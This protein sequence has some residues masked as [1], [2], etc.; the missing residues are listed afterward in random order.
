M[1]SLPGFG[2][3]LPK[4]AKPKFELI[5]LCYEVAHQYCFQYIE[6][7]H[8]EL[9][10]TL[11]KGSGEEIQ[12]E[13]YFF[14]DKGGRKLG[15]RFDLTVPL[16]RFISDHRNEIEIPFKRFTYGNV[17][18]GEKPQKGRYRE[19][20]QIDFDIVGDSSQYSEIEILEVISGVLKRLG[21]KFQIHVNDRRIL[22]FLAAS[23]KPKSKEEFLRILDKHRKLSENEF[24]N[25]LANVLSANSVD[26]LMLYK[27]TPRLLLEE[28]QKEHK[29]LAPALS[30]VLDYF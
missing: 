6:T 27:Q 18:R 5:K 1:T 3:K 4:V 21:I 16:S 9:A 10:Q 15:L 29:F 8:I 17:F 19:F 7:P 12:K 28:F 22:D 2:D 11:T 26:K 24:I 13:I 14:T 20:T 25:Q 23:L 30:Q